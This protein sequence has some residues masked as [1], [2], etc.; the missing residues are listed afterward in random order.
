MKQSSYK[1]AFSC[2]SHL[3]C[4][5]RQVVQPKAEAVPK[6]APEGGEEEI[7]LQKC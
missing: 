3:S 7:N 5:V 6:S 4:V 1:A 2:G